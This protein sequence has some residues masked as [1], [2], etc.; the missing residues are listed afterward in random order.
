[1]SETVKGGTKMD[2]QCTPV[3]I[4]GGGPVGLAAA[5]HLVKRK[6]PFV[7]LEKSKSI[8][9]SVLEWG[10]VQMFSPW[11]FNIDKAAAELLR[12]HGWESPPEKELPRGR[13]LIEMYLHPLSE[14]PQ[15][16]PYIFTDSTVVAI[17]RKNMD[18]MK[19]AGREE[20]SYVVTF[21]TGGASRQVEAYA[22]IDAT[23]TWNNPNPIGSGGN[24]AIGED[25]YA[26]HIYYGIPDLTQSKHNHQYAGKTIAVI[27]SGHSAIH[28]LLALEQV[29]QD[30]EQTKLYWILRKQVVSETFGGGI[31]DELPARGELGLKVKRLVEEGR[32]HVT[33]LFRIN[34]LEKTRDKI[35]ISGMKNGEPFFIDGIDEII[36][37]TGS[38]PDFSFLRELRYHVDPAL[39]SVPNL[40]ELID[41]NVHSCGTVR[42]HGEA[43]LR[44]PE[45]GLYIVGSKSYGRAPTFLMATGYEQVRSVV[46]ALAGDWKAAEKVELH[47]PE[48]GVCNTGQAETGCC[49][50]PDEQH[51]TPSCC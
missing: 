29:K 15:F 17:N 16:K 37:N 1:M 31:S 36:V 35:K 48:T 50:T 46:A 30:D 41:P 18:K 39:E 19:S 38:R 47:L 42:P 25:L 24:K 33:T 10:H 26:P 40:A 21:E 2:N 5:A 11:E 51:I 6:K 23:G 3:A 4:I 44:L 14:L 27:G 20:T 8:A 13:E 34:Q 9:G 32:V 43:H 28:S 7:L 22:V 12:E 45:K 49:V